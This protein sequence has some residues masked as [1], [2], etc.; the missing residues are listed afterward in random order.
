MIP[1]GLIPRGHPL[2]KLSIESTKIS[3]WST[4]SSDLQVSRPPAPVFSF[5]RYHKKCAPVTHQDQA[6]LDS[7]GLRPRKISVPAA[8]QSYDR[9]LACIDQPSGGSVAGHIV[10][11]SVKL[12]ERANQ[13]WW[14]LANPI[15][16]S[17]LFQ[18][19]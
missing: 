1:R 18:T 5:R 15:A 6:I 10:F 2:G 8:V 13:V 4:G 16:G 3:S 11:N 7:P 12:K 17:P 19:R 9:S 14:L